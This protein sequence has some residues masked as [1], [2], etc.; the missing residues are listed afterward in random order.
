MANVLLS[1]IPYLEKSSMTREKI[2]EVSKLI[3]NYEESSEVHKKLYEDLQRMIIE[4][5]C[6]FIHDEFDKLKK[7]E[8][9]GSG[10]FSTKICRKCGQCFESRCYQHG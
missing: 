7:G 8:R 10:Y 3:K 9:Y 6:K 2:E 4:D 5:I 1:E